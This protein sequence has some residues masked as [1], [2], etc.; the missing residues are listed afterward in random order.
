MVTFSPRLCQ[1]PVRFYDRIVARV[2]TH[3]HQQGKNNS[4][5]KTVDNKTL[6]IVK[7]RAYSSRGRLY[8][9]LSSAHPAL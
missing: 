2:L 4:D 9:S 8:N 7:A 1:N 6:V 3:A 5:E